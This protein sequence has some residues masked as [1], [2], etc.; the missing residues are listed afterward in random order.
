M[1]ALLLGWVADRAFGDPRRGHPVAG[2]GLVAERLERLLWHDSRGTGAVFA[3][4]LV[5]GATAATC[6]VQRRLGPHPRAALLTLVTWA[7][8]GS[9][10]L[11]L[12]AAGV[13]SAVARGDLDAARRRLPAL[14][15]RDPSGLDAG[16]L[17]RAVVE[18]LAENTADAVVASLVWG[19]ATGPAGVVAHRCVNTLDA[20]VG[21]RSPR[22]ERFGW[23][24]ARLD[25]GMNWLPA[26]ITALLAAACA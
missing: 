13:G 4:T 25:D 22:Y 16:Q 26:R 17:C 23:A 10:S 12:Q 11:G 8:L 14:C 6:A 15:G 1:S 20:M 21:H 24:A 5:G 2:F 9:R 3:A 19:A 7:A 18:S